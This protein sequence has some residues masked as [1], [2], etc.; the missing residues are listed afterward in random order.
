MTTLIEKVFGPIGQT[1]YRAGFHWDGDPAVVQQIYDSAMEMGFRKMM[2]YDYGD[3][4]EWLIQA[5]D[6]EMEALFR[7]TWHDEIDVVRFE[8]DKKIKFPPDWIT[9]LLYYTVKY[10]ERNFPLMLILLILFA[11]SP[12]LLSKLLD[13]PRLMWGT[14]VVVGLMTSLAFI[15]VYDDMRIQ[16]HER[17]LF[18]RGGGLHEE[19]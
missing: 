19:F 10:G 13:I 14:M 18:H 5:K 6:E 16:K 8:H 3:H 9:K 12:V 17:K 2:Y 7:L 11:I 15:R 1:Q 4:A